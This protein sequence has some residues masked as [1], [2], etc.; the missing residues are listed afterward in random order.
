MSAHY[1]AT[2]VHVHTRLSVWFWQSS[3]GSVICYKV[4]F[5][6]TTNDSVTLRIVCA[7]NWIK[8]KKLYFRLLWS[9][10]VLLQLSSHVSHFWKCFATTNSLFPPLLRLLIVTAEVLVYFHNICFICTFIQTYSSER[11]CAV[12]RREDDSQVRKTRF[13]FS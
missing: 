2:H 9:R 6:T 8:W 12:S 1:H 10:F 5:V 11:A 3:S 13:E 7:K 4:S